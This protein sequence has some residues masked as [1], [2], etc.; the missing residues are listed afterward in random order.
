MLALGL[1]LAAVSAA[2]VPRTP[3]PG[4]EQAMAQDGLKSFN[5]G[6][7]IRALSPSA[8]EAF[9]IDVDVRP[10]G[11]IASARSANG[12]DHLAQAVAGWTFVPFEGAETRRRT[13]TLVLG[14]DDVTHEEFSVSVRYESPLTLHI[15][16]HLPLVIRLPRVDGAIPEKICQVH[17]QKMDVELIP[18]LWGLIEPTDDAMTYYKAWEKKFPNVREVWFGGCME[19]TEQQAEMYICAKCRQARAAWIAAHPKIKPAD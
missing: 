7:S 2:G 10:N 4:E 3:Q 1:P 16:R 11:T 6:K 13:I 9:S 8:G 15:N 19:G 18:I 12:D 14:T 5:V 17:N